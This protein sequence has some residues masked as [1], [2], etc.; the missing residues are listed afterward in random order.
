MSFKYLKKII[1]KILII[2]FY[3]VYLLFNLINIFYNY[4]LIEI[5]GIRLGHYIGELTLW[6]LE[7]K[8]KKEINKTIWICNRNTCN[9]FFFKKIKKKI[10][11]TKNYFFKLLLEANKYYDESGK[12]II[13]RGPISKDRDILDLI[14]KNETIITFS[15]KEISE[16]EKLIKQLGIKENQQFVCICSRDHS[17]L[18]KHLSNHSYEYLDYKNSNIENYNLM[19]KNLNKKNIFVIRMG[20]ESEKKWSLDGKMNFDYSRSKFRS[21]FLDLYLVFRS[22]FVVT[23][24]TGFYILPTILKK[25]IVIVDFLPIDYCI[26]FA[27]NS[28]HIFKHLYDEQQKTI[29]KLDQLVSE[30]YQFLFTQKDYRRKNLKV[31]DNS[32]EEINDCVMEMNDRLDKKWEESANEQYNQNYFWKIYPKNRILNFHDNGKKYKQVLHGKIYSKIGSN[33]LKKYI[34][35]NKLN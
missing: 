21:G 29:L 27:K 34:D 23:T 19:T 10:H 24:G 22:K 25:P 35:L 26:T 16:G 4:K 1:L 30:E 20:R 15:K 11:I 32:P 28:I 12:N 8:N 5:S 18:K 6:Y 31:V 2:L 13:S 9:E 17:Y 33:Y 7:N 14:N 3:P